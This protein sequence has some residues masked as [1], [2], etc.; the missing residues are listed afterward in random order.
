MYNGILKMILIGS[1]PV[2]VDSYK[3]TC[4]LAQK[5]KIILK[6]QKFIWSEEKPE[7]EK[8]FLDRL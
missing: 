6:G 7:Y 4:I 8:P 3:T 5:K 1:E 2:I